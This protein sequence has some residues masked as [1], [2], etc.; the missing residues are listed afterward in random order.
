M[1][2]TQL[3]QS[4]TNT[5][6]KLVD[7]LLNS[8]SKNEVEKLPLCRYSATEKRFIEAYGVVIQ[9]TGGEMVYSLGGPFFRIKI[10]E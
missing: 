1:T 6:L 2:T 10:I 7:D 4:L 3:I 8:M 5:H 9:L